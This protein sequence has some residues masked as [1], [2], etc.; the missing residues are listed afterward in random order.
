MASGSAGGSGV[1]ME[2]DWKIGDEVMIW[3]KS[4][5]RGPRV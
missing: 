1:W 4:I 2:Q 3:E 5:Q